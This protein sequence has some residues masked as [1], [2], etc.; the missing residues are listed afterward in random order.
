MII[1]IKRLENAKDLPLPKYMTDGSAG[2]DLYANVTSP[3]TIIP[4]TIML[5]PTGISVEIPHGYEAQ[6]RPRSGLA[7]KYG[8]SLVNTPGTIDSD[9]RGEINLIMINFGSKPYEIKRGD[10]IAQMV[11]NKIEIPKIV[12]VEELNN[13]TRANGGFGST[14]L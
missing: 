11:I 2:L 3:V 14:G 5:I 4:N 10:R 9:Y 12:E 6:I 8:I 1:Y 13:T 7:L